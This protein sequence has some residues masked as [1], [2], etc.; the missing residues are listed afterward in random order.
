MEFVDSHCH[1]Q[2]ILK[3]SDQS[4]SRSYLNYDRSVEEVIKD[5]QEEAVSTLIVVGCTLEDSRLAIKLAERYDR[6]WATVGIH[7]H[8]ASSFL[9]QKTNQREFEELLQSNKVVGIGE[10]GL[11]YHYQYS[12]KED[13]E[14]V[15]SFQLE[16]AARHN[17]A[18]TF[19]VREAF[20]DFWDIL[21]QTLESA[22]KKAVLHSFTDSVQNLEIA[23]EK[24]FMIGV[25]GIA[26]FSRGP[27]QKAL[28]KSIPLHNLILETDSPYLTPSPI[29]GT[30]NE[31]KN[32][33]LIAEYLHK[34]RGE[35]LI[36]LA[37]QT[38]MNCRK[39]FG[40]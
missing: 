7:P 33:R 22:P 21:D 1:I 2:S 20:M 24:N 9:K 30:I 4:E 11:D 32:I 17:L 18:L 5:A 3:R 8:E 27:V 28:F 23:L 40:I 16:V 6:V 31:P 15:L 12:R 35:E 14:Q 29:R 19:H 10:C 34:L 38:T 25:N 37:T 36:D 13:Q 39:L 26:T